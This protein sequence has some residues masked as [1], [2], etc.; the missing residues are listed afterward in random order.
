L[1]AKEPPMFTNMLSKAKAVKASRF[2]LTGGSPRLRAAAKA[3]GFVGDGV[4]DAIPAP[5]LRA[6]AA[7]CGVDPDALDSAAPVSSGSG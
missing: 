6:L 5:R 7:A 1:A 2:D 4:P 3:A